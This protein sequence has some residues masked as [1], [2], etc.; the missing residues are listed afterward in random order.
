M[1]WAG[2][3][4]IAGWLVIVYWPALHGEFVWDD[5]ILVKRNPLVTGELTLSTVWFH[6]DFPLTI[7]VLWL[8]WLT[9]GSHAFGYHIVNLCFHII[10][11]LALWRVIAQCA[12][13][14]MREPSN[15]LGLMASW[16]GALLFAIHP[17][18]A[19]SVG[20][21]SEQKNTLSLIFYLGSLSTFLAWLQPLRTP[22]RRWY[23]LLSF[24]LS[25]LAL[26]SKTS[27][28]M[29]PGTF[30]LLA[31]W[32]CGSLSRKILLAAAPFFLLSLAFGLLTIWFQQHQTMT[33]GSLPSVS[34]AA[35]IV[36]AGM[37]AW[38]YLGK[39]II[40]LNLSMI[41]P[42]W[43]FEGRSLLEYFPLL[44]LVAGLFLLWKARHSS[45]G[46]SVLVV[47]LLF[48]LNLMP[49][50]GLVDMYY[51]SMSRV[52]DH[53]QYLSLSM[54]MGAIGFALFLPGLRKF[55]WLAF[56]AVALCFSVLTVQ[57]VRV[58]ATDETLWTDTLRHNPN[59]WTSHNNLGCIR[60]EQGRMDEAMN[61][62]QASLKLNPQNAATHANL[63]RALALQKDFTGAENQL[64]VAL[65]LKP[66]D[67][68]INQ[69][70]AQILLD[71]G[72]TDRALDHQQEAAA[73]APTAEAFVLLGRIYQMNRNF[74][75]AEQSYRQ[76]IQKNPNNVEALNNLAWILATSLDPKLRNGAEA[77]RYGE[78]ACRLTHF[79]SAQTMGTLAAAY[80]EAARFPEAIESAREAADLADAQGNQD[81][82]NV[83]RQL[84]RLYQ[85]GKAF[86]Q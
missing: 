26:L 67:A 4:G 27:T 22:A 66:S 48:F 25:L 77:V 44:A 53:F 80:A 38:F 33:T 70:F 71:E 47:V 41:Y 10:A 15:S 61:H 39:A 19:A 85:S 64:E 12:L 52:S 23:Y 43:H 6:T 46:K 65:A 1:I 72:K 29:L 76:A 40:P 49:V 32:L 59:S 14:R 16:A 62:F 75:D 34:W 68:E 37:A 74:A 17:V 31:W 18:T 35:K 50:L 36:M 28:V 55:G 21:I 73:K 5:T 7:V 13:Y 57:R 54:L 81:F 51:L 58:L 20:W 56:C 60:A 79:K 82:A 9:F 78:E 84:I 83:N 30:L 8:Q 3:A 45:F 86:H 69:I 42:Q 24:L 11:T 2:V 63:G